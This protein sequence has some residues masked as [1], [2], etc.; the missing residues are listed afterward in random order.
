ML[1]FYLFIAILCFLSL[2]PKLQK[3]T[4]SL[5]FLQQQKSARVLPTEA[6]GLKTLDNTSP[7]EFIAILDV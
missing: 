7:N 6:K 2:S 3:S 4:N 1:C 5:I